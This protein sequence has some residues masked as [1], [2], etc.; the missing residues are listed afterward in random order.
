MD[1][2]IRREKEK[3]Y[4]AVEELTREAFWN[5]NFPGCDEHYLVHTLRKHE[6]FI[7]GM[8]YVVE[9]EYGVIA[10]IMYAKSY[11][12]DENGNRINTITFGPL[13]VHPQYQRKGIG[14]ALIEYTR[15]IAVEKKVPAII[16]LGHPH[17]YCKHGFKNCRDYNISDINGRY[18]YGQLV[19]ELEKGVFDGGRWKFH[20]S[21]VYNIDEVEVE[22]FDS[23]F[24]EKEKGLKS[25]QV[26]FS[27]A[28][29]AF[30]D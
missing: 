21:Q 4:R 5:L 3:D 16:I 18:P 15:D 25:S 27:M 19:L 10:N 30:L 26:E 12:E 23:L 11:V 6:D 9:K 22:K 7:P 14:T 29:R 20:Y 28:V 24:P 8:D 17:N 13:S 2:V 1:M